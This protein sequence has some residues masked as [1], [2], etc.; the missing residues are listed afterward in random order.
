MADFF[1]LVSSGG[2]CLI[3]FVTLSREIQLLHFRQRVRERE[4]ERERDRGSRKSAKTS[5]TKTTRLQQVWGDLDT[6]G[7][8]LFCFD[9]ISF[10]EL[11]V[12][13]YCIVYYVRS[14]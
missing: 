12:V 14:Y 9:K 5:E 11:L 8:Q 13:L 7:H 10:V 4:R 2:S 6:T 1:L 3:T